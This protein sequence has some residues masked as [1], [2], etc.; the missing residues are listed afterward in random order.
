MKGNKMFI[1]IVCILMAAGLVLSLIVPMFAIGTPTLPTETAVELTPNR[2]PMSVESGSSAT[3]GFEVDVDYD[4]VLTST[5]SAISLTLEQ[6]SLVGDL[7]FP[8]TF[9]SSK[10][11]FDIY[12]NVVTTTSSITTSE[13]AII[14]TT[15]SAVEYDTEKATA[16][17]SDEDGT[18]DILRYRFDISVTAQDTAQ[19]R[20]YSAPIDIFYMYEDSLGDE[21]RAAYSENLAF[22]VT[23]DQS[24]TNVSIRR[25]EV[26]KDND[27]TPIEPGDDFLLEV[28]IRNNGDYYIEDAQVSV[29]NL[30][31]NTFIATDLGNVQYMDLPDG[32]YRYA[33]FNLRASPEITDGNYLITVAVEYRDHL[34]IQR[35]EEEQTTVTVGDND[36][37]PDSQYSSPIMLID[38]Y[39]FGGDSVTGGETFSLS[40]AF[41][42]TNQYSTVDNVRVSLNDQSGVFIPKNSSNTYFI[43]FIEPNGTAQWT[44]SMF[45]ATTAT[46][47]PYQINVSYQYEAV[48]NGDRMAFTEN[49]LIS[50]PLVQPELLTVDSMVLPPNPVE[51]EDLPIAATFVNK[52]KYTLTNLTVTVEGDFEGEGQPYYVGS[53]EQGRIDSYDATV[54]PNGTGEKHGA[55][56][57]NYDNYEGKAVEYRQEFTLNVTEQVIAIQEKPTFSPPPTEPVEEAP[58]ITPMQIAL[59]VGGLLLLTMVLVGLRKLGQRQ[60]ALDEVSPIGDIIGVKADEEKDDE[61][62]L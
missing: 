7:T 14:T 8:L 56:V 4:M 50:I 59:G 58:Q 30:S 31:T 41:R 53:L 22:N 35:V 12:T 16:I 52:G 15:Y 32:E 38:S 13:G 18:P 37:I 25:I 57:F 48:V 44:V 61:V 33:L 29:R 23:A 24:T 27:N 1:R 11:V 5:V 34:D 46:P 17:D 55:F 9:G 54:T 45:T 39:S 10:Y 6:P 28:A 47:K 26:I 40:M 2:P 51:G 62:T 43:P 49:E 3:L 60:M 20:S 19:T 36:G 42:N 21:Q